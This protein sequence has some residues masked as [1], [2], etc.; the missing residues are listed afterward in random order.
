MNSYQRP[1]IAIITEGHGEYEAFP[2]LVQRICPGINYCHCLNAKGYGNITS[3][4]EQ[5]IEDAIL[6][7]APYS[8]VCCIDLSDVVPAVYSDCATLVSNILSRYNSWKT[9][10]GSADRY[11]QFLPL[12][13]SVVVQRQKLETWLLADHENLCRKFGLSHIQISEKDSS[14]L[15]NLLNPSRLL[16]QPK[17]GGKFD[18]KNPQDVKKAMSSCDIMRMTGR[19]RSFRKFVKE[20]SY[21]SD[22][23][24]DQH[25]P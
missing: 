21:C 9:G 16:L 5:Y 18:S 23:W 22:L 12:H 13:F 1:A 14:N 8:I 25:A 19:S 2:C 15:D 10:P 4:L 3:R 6:G 7:K 24:V 20:I 11:K 17:S